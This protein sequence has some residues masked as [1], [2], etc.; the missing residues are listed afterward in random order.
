MKTQTEALSLLIEFQ[1]A[2][3]KFCGEKL[4][5]LHVNNASELIQGQMKTYCKTKGIIYKK[6]VP[7]SPPQNGVAECTNLTICSMAHAM[8]INANLCDFFWPF[9]VLTATYIKQHV[10]YSSLPPNTTPFQL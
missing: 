9:A 5:T 3:E 7:D 8:L 4:T 1:M 2:A 10:P 6:M